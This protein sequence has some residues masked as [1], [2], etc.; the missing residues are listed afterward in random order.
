MS[1]R[2]RMCPNCCKENCPRAKGSG[3]CK[4]PTRDMKDRNCFICGEKHL[5][6][7]CP[8][9]QSIKA[10]EDAKPAFFGALVQSVTDGE[11]VRPKKTVP[12]RPS[13]K[14]TSIGEMI[15]AA[16][17]NKFEVLACVTD[18]MQDEPVD[19]PVTRN[20]FLVSGAPA[21]LKCPNRRPDRLD[22]SMT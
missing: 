5:A 7:D 22:G 11:F 8:K 9:K 15:D 13:P 21:C 14:G 16:F 12:M 18:E 1:R 2:P 19:P 20:A 10:I 6:K 4:E 17:K 3:P